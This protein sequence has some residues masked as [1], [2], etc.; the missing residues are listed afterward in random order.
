MD[1]YILQ[2]SK[3]FPGVSF[4]AGPGF[5]WSP[6]KRQIIYA[7]KETVSPACKWAIWHELGH[8]LLNHF[9]Y[10]SDFE[11]LRL[12]VAAW[13][14]AEEIAASYKEKIKEDHIQNCLDT[15]REWLHRRST[16]PVC[17]NR[18]LQHSAQQYRCFNCH[19]TWKVST[20][21]F[22]RPYRQLDVIIKESPA[23]ISEQA[24][25]R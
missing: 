25:F 10:A 7:P 18:S 8:A 14:K 21:R 23:T 6:R 12:E 15:Y 24:I 22:C 3:D 11:L 19:T 17:G 5:C 4:V 13:Q 9:S 20:S 1:Q 2:L 16:C